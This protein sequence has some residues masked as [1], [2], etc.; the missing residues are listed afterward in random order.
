MTRTYSTFEVARLSDEDLDVSPAWV[1]EN[2]IPQGEICN[3]IGPAGVGKSTLARVLA[4][5]AL[6]G[7]TL[8]PAFV[9]DESRDVILVSVEDPANIVVRGLLRIEEAFLGF[10]VDDAG[11]ADRDDVLSRLHVVAKF[12]SGAR[13]FELDQHGLSVET[14]FYRELLDLT[15]EFCAPLLILDPVRAFFA[16]LDENSNAHVSL[17]LDSCKS[18]SNEA[19]AT[20]VLVHHTSKAT[21]E[22][23][24]ASAWRANVRAQWSLTPTASGALLHHDKNSWGP[25]LGDVELLRNGAVLRQAPQPGDLRPALLAWIGDNQG[26][27]TLGAIRQSRGAA[28]KALLAACGNPKPATAAAVVEELV[29]AGDVLEILGRKPN[30]DPGKFLALSGC[31]QC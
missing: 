8:L 7:K 21:G 10:P 17:F 26:A 25:A 19:E 6:T 30:G 18:F 11:W 1:F 29:E 12:R 13:F 24:G 5:S 20:V 23:R 31:A 15:S 4:L 3:I 2:A 14:D 27:A 16:G 28:A 9:P 22:A